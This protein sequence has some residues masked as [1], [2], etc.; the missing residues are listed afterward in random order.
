MTTIKEYNLFL[1]SKYR[2]NGENASPTFLL[3]EPIRLENDNNYFEG[4][5]KIL[6]ELLLRLLHR[7]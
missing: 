7:Q 4:Q 6:T 3:D 2:S 1:D 5:T